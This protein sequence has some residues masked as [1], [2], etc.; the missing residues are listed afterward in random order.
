[1]QASCRGTDNSAMVDAIAASSGRYRGI[2]MVARDI[3]RQEPEELHEGG[4]RGVRFSFVTHLGKGADRD[5]VREIVAKIIP[6]GWHAV[7]HFVAHR[8][9]GLAPCLKE[10]GLPLVIDNMGLIDAS[11]G[12]KQEAF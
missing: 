1:V 6:L 8:L 9:A 12:L 4:I 5:A 7:I 10:L 11:G 2:G 3:S